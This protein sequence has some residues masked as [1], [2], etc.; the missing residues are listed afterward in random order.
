M[1]DAKPAKPKV[2]FAE[3]VDDAS[4]LSL[5]K[6][7]SVLDAP[8]LTPAPA[9]KVTTPIVDVTKPTN[10][11]TTAELSTLVNKTVPLESF[12]SCK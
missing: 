8:I 9:T 5:G 1:A 7:T 11:V 12:L 2:T 3:N 4:T 10:K 6:K